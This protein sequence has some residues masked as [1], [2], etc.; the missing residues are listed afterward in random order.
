[1]KEHADSFITQYLPADKGNDVFELDGKGGK[2]ILR[3]NNGISI[4]SALNYYLKNYCHCLITWNGVNMQ[5]P[6]E[7]PPVREKVRKSSPYKY[8]YYLNY[9]TFNYSMAWWD[10]ERWQ[11][12]IDWM[13]LNGINMPLALTGEEAIWNK[14]Y[15]RLGFTEA[16]L[17]NFF[18]G[19]AYF[20]WLWMGNLDAWQVPLSLHWMDSHE[21]LQKQILQA[22]RAMG[23]TPVLPA[24]TG[25]VPPS[26]NKKFPN[27]KVKQ[28]NWHSGFDDV[29]ILDPSDPL[30]DSIGKLFLLEQTRSF[31]TDHLYSADTFNENVP[32]TDDSL[33]LDN[34]SK[35]VLS[36]MTA[37]DPKA[38]WVMQG[39]MF[40]F[41]SAYWKQKQIQAL[42][43]AVP[44]DH[45]II[46]D[47]YAESFPLWKT[48]KAYYGKPWIWN[49]LHN[50]GGNISL[51]GRM[52]Q[53]AK[54]P[55]LALN[56][57]HSGKMT[58]IGLT[59]EA[60]EQ[61][62]ALY[63][64][65]LENVWQ[66]TPINLPEWLKGYARQ[67]YG[68]RNKSVDEAW[69]ILANSVYKGGLTEG[70]PESIISARPTLDS[71]NRWART[72]LDYDPSE[73]VK[74]WHLFA[75]AIP[76]L[77]DNDGFKYDLVDITRQ[78][79]ANY[80][81]VI[82]QQL[83]VA[84]KNK[85]WPDF[86]RHA[87]DFMQTMS[88]LDALL[89]TRADFLLGK[90]ISDARKNGIDEKEK[91]RYERNARN[92]VTLWGDR[93]SPLHDYSC[94]QWNGLI[95]GFYQPRW[96]IFFASLDTAIQSGTA[97]DYKK[98]EEKIKAWEWS[99]VNDHQPYSA[100]PTL[101][102]ISVSTQLLKKY[103][104]KVDTYY[105]ITR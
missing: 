89:G 63:H 61:N 29:S 31:G 62:P 44:D 97:P 92:L 67:R 53:A 27:A 39:W 11:Q 7:L 6:A 19:P 82:H 73:L 3:G 55:A 1:M 91:D 45:M 58:G 76:E 99:W 13:T 80:A 16:Q 83:A 25:H 47:L 94:R 71:S 66:D 78:V 95:S 21:A 15:R 56:D 74:A 65:M 81:N 79:L 64:L 40:H 104:Q 26:F 33:F 85:N 57:Q 87:S 90:W 14:V 37:V 2:I 103:G 101:M 42:L 75:K 77:K 88:D 12:E 38:V 36:G 84:F 59:P 43:N 30:F 49:V 9:C 34:I 50:F 48:T 35:K 98:I 22:E 46:L 24:F 41:N 100:R 20:S 52:E 105:G 70:G 93:D 54:D 4:G 60:I 69:L 86:E 68:A 72:K 32:P 102:E 96:K 18:S 28:T 8:R 17:N 5:L 23:M 10:W 51:W